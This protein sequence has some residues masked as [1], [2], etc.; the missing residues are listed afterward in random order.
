LDRARSKGINSDIEGDPEYVGFHRE[1]VD[2]YGY[3]FLFLR[4]FPRY[5][6]EIWDSERADDMHLMPLKE[7]RKREKELAAEAEAEEESEVEETHPGTPGSAVN[8]S[9]VVQWNNIKRYTFDMRNIGQ[10][11]R[12]NVKRSVKQVAKTSQK[13]KKCDPSEWDALPWDGVEKNLED[14]PIHPCISRL[15]RALFSRENKTP[16]QKLMVALNSQSTSDSRS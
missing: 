4:N 8:D 7:K 16:L 11:M 5:A 9:T 2:K 13:P 3:Y 1:D 14:V 12:I 10:L 6:A 15:W